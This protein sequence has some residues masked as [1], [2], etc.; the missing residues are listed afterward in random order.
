[1]KNHYIPILLTALMLAGACRKRVEYI[2]M[3][4]PTPPRALADRLPG[5][6]TPSFVTY[7]AQIDLGQQGLPPINVSGITENPNGRL[8]V[9][10][11]PNTLT[12]QLQFT[13]S[14]DL[15]LGFPVPL[16]VNIN[17]TGTY[18]ISTDEKQ[19]LL[20]QTNGEKLT[21]KVLTNEHNVQVWRTTYPF[22]TPLLGTLPIDMIITFVKNQAK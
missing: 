10:K 2:Y 13:A 21:L 18:D 3:D 1:M 17:L 15:G 22:Q 9:Q 7:S 11:D 5:D 20:T 12:I 19:I 16:P 4:P 14:I 8:T 6:W